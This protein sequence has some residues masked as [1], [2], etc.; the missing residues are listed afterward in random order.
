MIQLD[1]K[2]DLGPVLDGV[3]KPEQKQ[4]RRKKQRNLLRGLQRDPL[5]DL[6]FADSA[7]VMNFLDPPA[8]ANPLHQQDIIRIATM[9]DLALLG[10]QIAG[11]NPLVDETE[12]TI[13]VANPAGYALQN[14][15]PEE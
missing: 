2:T 4:E 3:F 6:K 10:N 14:N 13:V 9:E 12:G 1:G 5:F 8:D 7:P 11:V 15:S